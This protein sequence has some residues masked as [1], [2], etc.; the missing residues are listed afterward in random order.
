MGE[1]A[2]MNSKRK[3]RMLQTNNDLKGIVKKVF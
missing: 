1:D 3:G 2:D